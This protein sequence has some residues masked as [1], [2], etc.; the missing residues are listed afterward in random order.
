MFTVH[1]MSILSICFI[2][3]LVS[4]AV[5]DPLEFFPH[6]TQAIATV[7]QVGET[8]V[9][10]NN[11]LK[12]N[13]ALA[14]YHAETK[15]FPTI[16]RTEYFFDQQTREK[17]DSLF[18]DVTKH[19]DY[20]KAFTDFICS[21]ESPGRLSTWAA[22][23]FQQTSSS[24]IFKFAK[25]YGIQ[26][27]KSANNDLDLLEANADIT[28]EAAAYLVPVKACLSAIACTIRTA[29]AEHAKQSVKSK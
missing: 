13:G 17:A 25:P 2:S 19:E 16:K 20:K 22:W 3:T 18:A 7:V 26:P 8:A 1:R 10:R 15:R 6:Y 28:K 24:L 12:E 11:I 27:P 4:A 21:L 23:N 9:E 29:Q 14:I 5:C